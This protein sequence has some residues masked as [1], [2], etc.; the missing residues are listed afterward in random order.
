MTQLP[1]NLT[2]LCLAGAVLLLCAT[3][4][5]AGFVVPDLEESRLESLEAGSAASSSSAPREDQPASPEFRRDVSNKALGTQSSN[6]NMS[7]QG[8]GPQTSGP[9]P[10]AATPP[11]IPNTGNG[12]LIAYLLQEPALLLPVPFLDGVF[13]PPRG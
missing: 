13:R 6:G 9:A 7:G 3:S 8:T 11:A 12:G 4:A 2:R 5:Q 1:Y 10:S